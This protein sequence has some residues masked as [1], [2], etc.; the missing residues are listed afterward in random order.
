MSDFFELRPTSAHVKFSGMKRT[1]QD[2]AEKKKK[3]GKISAVKNSVPAAELMKFVADEA[4]VKKWQTESDILKL[5]GPR[6]PRRKKW[7]NDFPGLLLE[8]SDFLPE[9][10][11][12]TVMHARTIQVLLHFLLVKSPVLFLLHASH[13]I[14]NSQ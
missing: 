8:I 3:L 13:D 11:G 5:L 10:V 6:P 9:Q 1:G 7:M 4:A 12:T 14:Q 2:T